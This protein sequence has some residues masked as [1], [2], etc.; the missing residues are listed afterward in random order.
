MNVGWLI[1]QV[2]HGPAGGMALVHLALV[3][4]VVVGGLAYV[5][6]RGARKG[7]DR[8]Q[9]RTSDRE[10]GRDRRPEA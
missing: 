10:A 9:P 8:D 3:A 2:N 6:L 4:I 1:A 5:L 7:S